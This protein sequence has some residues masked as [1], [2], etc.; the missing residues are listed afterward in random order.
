MHSLISLIIFSTIVYSFVL[1]IL[2]R[3]IA[4]QLILLH[5]RVLILILLRF[6]QLTDKVLKFNAST[7]MLKRSLL[8]S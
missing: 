3:L 1:L 4:T 6:I 8:V 2:R 5:M 7:S